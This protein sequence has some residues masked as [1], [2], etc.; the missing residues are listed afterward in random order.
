MQRLPGL[1]LMRAIAIIW[2]M[3]FHAL[4]A[5][6][7]LPGETIA[8]FGWM[9]VDLF[10]ALSGFLIGGQLFEQIKDHGRVDFQQ[11][12]IRRAYRIL[13]A[14]GVV[15]ACYFALPMIREYPTIQPWWQF[16]TFTE[17]L[18]IDYSQPRAFSHVWSLCV[19]EHF[20]LIMPA[21]AWLLA[22]RATI[23][24]I[25]SL[26]V[27]LAAAGMLWRWHVWQHDLLPIQSIEEGPGNFYQRYIEQIY[28]PTYTRLDGLLAGVMF[29]ALRVFRPVW[30]QR[31]MARANWVL[32][33]GL[34]LVSGAIWIF[35][36]RFALPAAVLGYP[37][38]SLGMGVL[39]VAAASRQSLIGARGIPGVAWV[40]ALSYSLYLTHKVVF[41][42]V[43]QAWGA[44]LVGQPALAYLV[45]G[46]AAMLGGLIL[47]WAVERPALQWRER[48]LHPAKP[49]PDLAE[50]GAVTR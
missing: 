42:L 48:W 35:Q 39:V 25:T 40:A 10:F 37:L 3:L 38:L 24:R 16:L 11:F 49:S 1:D 44:Q 12:Y 20:Y 26:A 31:I 23:S 33:A 19:E 4:M 45:Y 47:Y 34:L 28:Y 30:W 5:G 7:Q 27:A 43:K 13:P 14:F 36:N 29:A 32:G 15:V 50:M 21:L 9:G 41:H 6:L 17:N 46:G 2:V 8:R 22:P 18:L